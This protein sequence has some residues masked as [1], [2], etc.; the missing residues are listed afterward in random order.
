MAS[1]GKIPLK[2]IKWKFAGKETL[3]FSITRAFLI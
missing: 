1:P 3:S 2:L